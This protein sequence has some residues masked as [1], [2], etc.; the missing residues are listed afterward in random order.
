MKMEMMMNKDYTVIETTT[1]Q[2]LCF[3][4]RAMMQGGWQPQ[5]GVFSGG[6][7]V[8][9]K[10]EGGED[11]VCWYCQALVKGNDNE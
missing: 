10:R 11:V 1:I 7:V 3:Q 6:V 2:E 5:G 9:N 4:V 8:E